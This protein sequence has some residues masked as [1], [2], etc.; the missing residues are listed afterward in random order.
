[1]RVDIFSNRGVFRR[2]S[3]LQ[4]VGK[5]AAVIVALYYLFSGI[6]LFAGGVQL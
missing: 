3:A 2:V 6:L 5:F 4:I 1:V